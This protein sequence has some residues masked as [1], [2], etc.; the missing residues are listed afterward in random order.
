MTE[1]LLF[2]SLVEISTSASA[3]LANFSC[4][5]LAGILASLITQP[6]DVVKTHVQVNPQ[7]RTAEAIR[8]IYMV[9]ILLLLH[10]D[11][12]AATCLLLL[13]FMIARAKLVAI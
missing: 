11:C 1:H 12:Q 10:S 5:I 3:P 2:D 13:L 7:L 4:G 9:N 6:A 8:Y